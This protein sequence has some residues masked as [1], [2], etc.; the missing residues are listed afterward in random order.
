MTIADMFRE[1]IRGGET[2]VV[3]GKRG[4]GKTAGA[5]SVAQHAI[6]GDWGHENVLVITNVLFG[7][8]VGGGK[9]PIEAYPPGVY[10]E[11]TLAGTMRRVGSI[12]EDYG[13]GNCTIIWLLDEAQNFMLADMNGSKENMALTKYLGNAR[14]FDVC[15][16]FLTPALNNLTPRVRCFPTGEAKSGYCSCQIIKDTREAKSIAGS[17]VDP[18]NI[19]FI[20]FDSGEEFQPIYVKPTPWI[21]DIYTPN[22]AIGDYGYDTKST[23]SFSI[24]ENASGTEF[25]FEKF[26]KATS[27]GLSHQLPEKISAFFDQWDS[28]T[29]DGSLPGEDPVK[30]RI[31]DQCLRIERMRESG[32]KW[33]DIAFFE[34]EIETTLKSRYKKF[35]KL[36][37]SKSEDASISTNDETSACA[38]AVYIQPIKRKEEEKSSFVTGEGGASA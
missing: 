20:R 7:K 30:V 17:R 3:S 12:L 38:H 2:V 35:I 21:H 4:A 11:D 8:V 6:N 19:S 15:N 16:M 24:G 14:K 18:R 23:A 10:H 32:L 25:S 13:S 31:R 28:E 34:G 26:I 37:S 1:I 5:I 29:E 22:A 27:G 36:S 9:Q 33:G